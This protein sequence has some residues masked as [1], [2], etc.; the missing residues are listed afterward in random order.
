MKIVIYV[1]AQDRAAALMV[2]A[3]ICDASR[4]PVSLGTA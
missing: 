3:N 2:S 4:I 1:A